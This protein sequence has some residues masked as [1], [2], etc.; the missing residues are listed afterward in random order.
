M[1]NPLVQIIFFSRFT[2]AY[3]R[4]RKTYPKLDDA[5]KGLLDQLREGQT[6]GDRVQGTTP[7]IVYKVR[8]PN[9][10]AGKGKS[11][12]FRVIYYLKTAD[13]I[14]MLSIYSKNEQEDVGS[15]DIRRMIQDSNAENESD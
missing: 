1:S 7:S 9:K 4:L 2:K 15:D 10:D 8:L 6:P 5:L 14:S 11:G 13:R 3:R 12:G